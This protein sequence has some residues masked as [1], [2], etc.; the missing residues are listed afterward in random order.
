MSLLQSNSGK[1]L[2]KCPPGKL[3]KE[4]QLQA[5]KKKLK[6]QVAGA[7]LV[8]M[9]KSMSERSKYF[10]ESTSLEWGRV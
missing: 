2:S 7:N 5:L 3:R 8:L 4:D 1:V 10:Q 6:T 9:G